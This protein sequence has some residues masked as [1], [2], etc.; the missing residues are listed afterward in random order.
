MSTPEPPTPKRHRRPSAAEIT[1]ETPIWCPSCQRYQPASDFNRESGRSSGLSTRCRE[2]QAAHRSRPD[3]RQA[4]RARRRKRYRED[5]EVR[6]RVAEASRQWRLVNG[7][8]QLVRSRARLQDIVDQW[9]ATGCVDCGCGDI[10]AIDPDHLDSGTKSGH[11][12]RLVQLCASEARIRAE[13]AKCVPRCARC[14]RLLTQSQRPSAWRSAERLPPSWRRRLDMQDRNDAIKL[15]LGCSDC[16]WSEWARGLDW[17]HVRGR[18]VSTIAILIA[19]GRPWP[20]VLEEM[21][22]CDLVCANCHR[23]RT[24]ERNARLVRLDAVTV[25]AD[26]KE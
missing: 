22:K 2:A 24:V 11:V 13:L 7:A 9:K 17:D 21:E 18:K 8:A 6:A 10:R 15:S 23:M 26:A 12:S 5:P 25:E 1:P 14:H 20:E 16:G 4:E 19:N 3:V